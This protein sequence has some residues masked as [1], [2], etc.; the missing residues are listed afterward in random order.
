M[1]TVGYVARRRRPFLAPN[2]PGCGSV[3]QVR[4]LV[5]EKDVDGKRCI[6]ASWH[7][8][9]TG[10]LCFPGFGVQFIMLSTLPS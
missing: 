9:N 7:W 3:G 4:S 10:R 2:L 6:A 1:F 8:I 5:I